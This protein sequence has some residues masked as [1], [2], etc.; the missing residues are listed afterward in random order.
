MPALALL[1][2]HQQG[3]PGRLV[4]LVEA[5]GTQIGL[6]QTDHEQGVPAHSADREALPGPFLE[7]RDRVARSTGQGIGGAQRARDQGQRHRHGQGPAEGEP[8][9]EHLDRRPH[10][11]PE[12]VERTDAARG[13]D[14]A[15]RV[16]RGLGEPGA[17]VA[18]GQP[19]TELAHVGQAVD[20]VDPGEDRHES[21]DAH[22]LADRDVGQRF[23]ALPEDLGR[24][25]VL[26]PGIVGGAEEGVGDDPE[27][28]VAQP[29]GERERALR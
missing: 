26:A 11:A 27:G 20:Q 8:A 18:V 13:E 25:A 14:Q 6:A 12:E 4:G 24:L 17:L 21:G 15:V 9:L 23:H 10:V 28:G 2:G 19:L 22:V 16:V 29:I 1:A 7:Q 3:P 5:A